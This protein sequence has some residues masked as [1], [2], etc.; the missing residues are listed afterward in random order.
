ML[1]LE[2]DLLFTFEGT[3]RKVK[4]IHKRRSSDVTNV[5]MYRRI[6]CLLL[7]SEVSLKK[8]LAKLSEWS[9]YVTHYSDLYVI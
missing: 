9:P 1:A 8:P 4:V 5:K 2:V 7:F 3:T 6:V